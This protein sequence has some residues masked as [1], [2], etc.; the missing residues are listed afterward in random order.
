MFVKCFA[1]NKLRIFI[2]LYIFVQRNR[3]M[4]LILFIYLFIWFL[5]SDFEW[6]PATS[7]IIVRDLHTIQQY[8][9]GT[10][11]V[12]CFNYILFN[13]VMNTLLFLVYVICIL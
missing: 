4:E 13:I 3:E 1:M 11:I 9:N 7:L 5:A 2:Q 8:W 6:L 12:I 10:Y